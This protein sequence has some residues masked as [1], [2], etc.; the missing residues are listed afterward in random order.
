M[1]KRALNPILEVVD[2]E[3]KYAEKKA[4]DKISFSIKPGICFGMLGPNGAGKTTTIE[5]IEGITAPT[6]GKIFYKGKPL[7]QEFRNQCGIQFQH[8]ALQEYLTVK[9]TLNLFKDF[10]PQSESLESLTESCN[11]QAFIHH[12]NQQLSGGQRQR[13]LLAIA[14]INKP[15]I[16]FLDEPTTGLDPQAR[17]NFWQLIQAV[18]K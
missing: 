7:G 10:Y 4:V 1:S 6:S 5:M 8:T 9:E 15:E 14:L 12:N 18:F 11:L 16:V 13:M 3:K 17:H 2:L